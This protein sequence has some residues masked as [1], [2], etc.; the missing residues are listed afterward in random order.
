MLACP[1]LIRGAV[2]SMGRW[3]PIAGSLAHWFACARL[4]ACAQLACTPGGPTPWW[5]GANAQIM[6]LG[7]QNDECAL[8]ARGGQASGNIQNNCWQSVFKG[9]SCKA[10][11]TRGFSM[12][13]APLLKRSV[14]KFSRRPLFASS[15]C[16]LCVCLMR[17][18]LVGGSLALLACKLAWFCTKWPH[19]QAAC[20]VAVFRPRP[21]CSMPNMCV[22]GHK[23]SRIARFCCLSELPS[24]LSAC[25]P[26]KKR[27]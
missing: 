24:V 18:C 5:R 9:I 1:L 26:S 17:A 15:E 4:V 23:C 25:R 14:C 21:D 3:L 16:C 8:T 20:S 7:N 10:A 11:S 13:F 22:S 19:C 12:R 6:D 2:T 27:P